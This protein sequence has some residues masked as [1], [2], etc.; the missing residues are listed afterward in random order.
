MDKSENKGKSAICPLCNKSHTLTS[1]FS[2][3]SQYPYNTRRTDSIHCYDRGI[4]MLSTVNEDSQSAFSVGVHIEPF[5]HI[6]MD[7]KVMPTEV[8]TA[9]D[10]YDGDLLIGY[11]TM[12]NVNWFEGISYCTKEREKFQ[13]NF[14]DDVLADIM[15][16]RIPSS[17]TGLPILGGFKVDD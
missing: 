16:S 6:I 14:F 9:W 12:M 1:R 2:P 7:I 17:V 5:R 4:T 13:G 3:S 8:E 11:I 15:R 10:V